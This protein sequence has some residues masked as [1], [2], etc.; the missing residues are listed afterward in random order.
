MPVK[1]LE[2]WEYQTDVCHVTHKAHIV[3]KVGMKPEGSINLYG[4]HE[5]NMD[6]LISIIFLMFTSV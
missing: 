5:H 1:V 4:L 2:K 6:N 3:C